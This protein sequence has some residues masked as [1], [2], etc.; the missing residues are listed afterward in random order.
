MGSLTLTDSCN[1][2]GSA[3]DNSGPKTFPRH[4][5]SSE[6]RTRNT[7]LLTRKVLGRPHSYGSALI[8]KYIFWQSENDDIIGYEKTKYAARTMTMM[9]TTIH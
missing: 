5:E 6:F 1:V 2:G 4:Y 3:A 8:D 7:D 9:M